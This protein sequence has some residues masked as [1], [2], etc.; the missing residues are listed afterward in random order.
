MKVQL[1]RALRVKINV[2]YEPYFTAGQPELLPSKGGIIKLERVIMYLGRQFKMATFPMS[3]IIHFQSRPT[4]TL[5]NRYIFT[6]SHQEQF[7]RNSK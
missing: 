1:K 2:P 3:G 4:C 7:V 6:E 5:S